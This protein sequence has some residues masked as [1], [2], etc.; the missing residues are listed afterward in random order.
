MYTLMDLPYAA[1]ALEPIISANTLGFH[2]GKHHKTYVDNLNNLVKGTEFEGKALADVVMGSAGKADKAAIF[3]NAAQIW[4]HDFYWKSLKPNGG[5]LPGGKVGQAIQDS[6][7][8]RR[9]QEADGR[10]H[11]GPVRQ[12][13]G[14]AL[15]GCRR[16]AE[17]RE[18]GQC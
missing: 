17:D 6:F 11:R 14:L 9:V 16:Q 12:R 3:N 1:N 7:D 18:D 8:L 5:G 4:N 15:R 13:L 10:H 2:H